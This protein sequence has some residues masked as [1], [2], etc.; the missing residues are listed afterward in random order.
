MLFAKVPFGKNLFSI[1][2]SE[3]GQSFLQLWHLSHSGTFKQLHNRSSLMGEAVG[4]IS[5]WNLRF[6]QRFVRFSRVCAFQDLDFVDA[7][8]GVHSGTWW[9]PVE[10]SQGC[11]CPGSP[12]DGA[13][14][15]SRGMELWDAPL[16]A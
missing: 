15:W 10:V 9:C 11:P 7:G 12:W 4:T 3:F 8:G 5:L 14:G 2:T 16:G 6:F 13:V 1:S